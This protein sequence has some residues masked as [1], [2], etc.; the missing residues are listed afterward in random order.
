MYRMSCKGEPADTLPRTDTQD[1]I[2]TNI[3]PPY[4]SPIS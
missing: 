1:W 2:D 3:V 4:R